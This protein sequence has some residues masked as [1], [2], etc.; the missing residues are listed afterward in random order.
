[1][2][3][4]INRVAPY[5]HPYMRLVNEND[6]LDELQKGLSDTQAFL[7]AVSEADSLYAYAPYKWTIREVA[8]HMAD[9]E[10]V[11]AYRALRIARGD[12]TPLAG[13]DEDEY[14][15]T[16]RFNKTKWADLLHQL[17]TVRE[18]SL[19]LFSSFD[20]EAFQR[21][22]VANNQP[23]FVRGLAYIIRGH[24]LHHLGVIRERYLKK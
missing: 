1:M 7:S 15:K 12:Q 14:V 20:E 3:T 21:E 22:G 5:Y 19:S 18:A 23:T 4:M 11:F 9:A 16:A 24:E 2:E 6:I 13:F 17:K 10:R 8:G